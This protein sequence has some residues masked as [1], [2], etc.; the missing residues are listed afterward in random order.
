MLMVKA[1]HWF[2]VDFILMSSTVIITDQEVNAM[3]GCTSEIG[4]VIVQN[5]WRKLNKYS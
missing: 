4:T 1:K 3:K 5:R 2:E